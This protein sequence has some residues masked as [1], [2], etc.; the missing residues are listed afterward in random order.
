MPTKFSTERLEQQHIYFLVFII[1]ALTIMSVAYLPYSAM[2]VVG[3][4]CLFLL[5]IAQP[6]LVFALFIA[7]ECLISEDILLMTEKLETTLYRVSLPYVGINIFEFML[8]LLALVTLLQRKGKPFGSRLDF[9]LFLFGCACVLGY[10]TCI[11]RYQDATRLFEPRRLIHLFAAYFLTVNLIRTK[12]SLQLFLWIY[13]AAIVFKALEGVVLYSMG[14][15]LQIKW[16]IRAIF[17]G[18]EDSLNFVTYLL[19]LSVFVLDRL[20]FAGKRLFLFFSPAV[21]F[22]FLFSYKRAYYIAMAVGIF[23]LFFLLDRKSRFRMVILLLAL[24]ILC[25]GI[26]TVAGQWQAIG[27]RMASIFQ[28]TKESSAN[29][30]L[31]EWQNAMISIHRNPVFGIGLGGVMP[32]EV[33]LSRTNL[34]GVHNTFLWVAVK[35]GIFGLF[36]YLFLHFAYL[37]RLIRLNRRLRDPFLRTVARALLC[38]FLAF[39]AAEMFAPMFAQMRTGTWLGVMMGIGMMLST[40]DREP[41]E[42]IDCSHQKDGNSS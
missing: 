42:K 27:M 21:F 38:S 7:V 25:M 13:F 12:R 16:R 34:L 35:M 40:L 5:I 26:I 18:W 24:A 32:M 33:F 17:T 11:V 41:L 23:A 36:T 19:F 20:Q 28:P 8:L 29:Y 3:I 15:G 10:V 14:A 39:C 30:R 37:Q 2:L 22:C 31:I 4:L 1:A 6:T 9:T